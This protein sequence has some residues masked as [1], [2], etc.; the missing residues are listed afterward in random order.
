M[1]GF[2]SL[3][4][5]R[6]IEGR[7]SVHLRKGLLLD[8]VFPTGRM[9]VVIDSGELEVR[10]RYGGLANIL[11]AGEAY[12][13]ANLFCDE[14]LPGR[15]RTRSDVELTLLPKAAVRHLMDRDTGLYH[16]YCRLVNRKLDFLFSRVELLS[17]KSNRRRVACYLLSEDEGP[18]PSRDALAD[19]L[20]MGRSALF[21]E[22]GYLESVGA[23]S[24]S[25]QDIVVLDRERLKE[26]ADA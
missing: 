1:Q 17:I 19:Y 26:V 24:Y 15:L 13:I 5:D 3:I 18:L 7:R 21:R 20:A 2:L 10:C 23:I 6:T 12:G 8:D 14:P 25:A 4:L 22:L 11:T 16:A 9:V